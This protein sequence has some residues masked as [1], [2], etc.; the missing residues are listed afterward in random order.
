MIV[1]KTMDGV[2]Y[3]PYCLG[4]SVVVATKW[5]LGLGANV[6]T[7]W[8]ELVVC[9]YLLVSGAFVIFSFNLG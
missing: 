1:F 7:S 4:G 9:K 2:T 8:G 3:L 6:D 5:F